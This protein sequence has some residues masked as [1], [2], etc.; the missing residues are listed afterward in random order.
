MLLIWYLKTFESYNLHDPLLPHLLNPHLRHEVSI[1]T[2]KYT[3]AGIPAV[4]KTTA[5]KKTY[6]HLFVYE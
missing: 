5:V 1:K 6:A 4:R 2:P 3:G